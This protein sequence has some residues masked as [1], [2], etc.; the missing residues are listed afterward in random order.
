MQTKHDVKSLCEEVLGKWGG[1]KIVHSILEVDD[2]D[3]DQRATLIQMLVER[4][5]LNR[6]NGVVEVR[7]YGTG[8]IKASFRGR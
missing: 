1:K 7:S 5:E 6:P 8:N 2:L 4:L 3:G